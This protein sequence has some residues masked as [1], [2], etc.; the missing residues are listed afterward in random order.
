MVIASLESLAIDVTTG[1]TEF[2]PDE[3]RER[4]AETTRSRLREEV[5][6]EEFWSLWKQ[7]ESILLYKFTKQCCEEDWFCAQHNSPFGLGTI[8]KDGA[9]SPESFIRSVDFVRDMDQLVQ[10][11]V[12]M[13]PFSPTHEFKKRKKSRRYSIDDTDDEDSKSIDYP[14]T[15]SSSD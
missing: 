15:P 1:I 2:L 9:L 13:K 6:Q 5:R 4:I 10:T 3:L 14:S 7:I 12:C 11:L 8:P